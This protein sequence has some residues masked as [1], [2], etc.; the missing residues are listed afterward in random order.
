MG[1]RF[2][3]NARIGLGLVVSAICLWLAIRQTPVDD[4]F[5]AL[6]RV[7]YW[8][9]VPVVLGNVLSLWVRG[10]RWR[11]LLANR[12][13]IG[14]Y[15]WAQSIGCLITNIFPLRA[16]EAGRV[17]I[18]SRRVGLPRSWVGQPAKQNTPQ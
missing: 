7:N 18:V 9:L 10:L 11:V 3:T 13:S 15:F 8:W 6:Q 12:G 1:N 16:G 14:E 5:D 4:L 2:G 17:V